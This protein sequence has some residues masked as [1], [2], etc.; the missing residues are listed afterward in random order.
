MNVHFG[1]LV[2]RTVGVT[3][4]ALVYGEGFMTSLQEFRCEICG[5]LT[6]NP[7]HWFVIQCGNLDLTVLKWNS[8]TANAAGA[9]HFCGEAHAQVYISRWFDSVCSPSKPD[10]TRSVLAK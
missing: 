5:T 7:I 3:S 9:R 10:F 8:E 6:S 2:W 1:D 4:G